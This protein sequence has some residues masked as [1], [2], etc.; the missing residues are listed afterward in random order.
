MLT[1][2]FAGKIPGHELLNPMAV[3]VVGGLITSTL[4]NLFLLP[5]LFL[6]FGEKREKS[7]GLLVEDQVN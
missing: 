4:I 6:R 3:A 1:L 7:F 5:I 2:S